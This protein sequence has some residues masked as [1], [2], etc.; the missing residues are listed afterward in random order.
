MLPRISSSGNVRIVRF[1]VGRDPGTLE[2]HWCLIAQ[3]AMRALLIVVVAEGRKPHAG[4]NCR[5][6]D[7]HVQAFIAHRAIEALL[8]SILPGAAW[9]MYSVVICRCASHRC[10]A[11]ATNSGPLSLRR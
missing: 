10:I 8:L 9:S 11:M 4:L 7:M 6:E 5:G 2:F 1:L 3:G